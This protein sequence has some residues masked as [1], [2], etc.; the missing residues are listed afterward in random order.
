MSDMKKILDAAGDVLEVAP[1][2][3]ADVAQPAAK[4]TGHFLERIPRAINAALSGIDVW[5]AKK[6]YNV[7]ET[8]KL[9]EQKL[10]K[11]DPEKIVPP[12][13]YVAVPAFQ[14][15]SYCMDSNELREMFANLLAKSMHRDIKK[16]VHPCFC[17]IIK[18]CSPLDANVLKEIAKT[19]LHPIISIY[20]DN[21]K[22]DGGVRLF[23]HITWMQIADISEISSSLDNLQKNGLI[24]ISDVDNYVDDKNYFSVRTSKYFSQAMNS[25]TFDSTFESIREQQG[26]LFITDFGRLFIDICLSDKP[27]L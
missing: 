10:S 12:E 5:I 8:K 27:L 23:R 1:E 13:P 20:R 26:I 4:Q 16:F 14:A 25:I 7:A 9:L 11:V 21:K 2:V 3:Y 15:I 24:E 6:E 18:Q 19:E 22:A 17:E